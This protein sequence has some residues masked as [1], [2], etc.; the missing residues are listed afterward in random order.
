MWIART[1][2]RRAKG[3]GIIKEIYGISIANA[4]CM[5]GG[6]GYPIKVPGVGGC[7]GEDGPHT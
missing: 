6:E 5:P 1:S 4:R 3:E 2:K 7:G